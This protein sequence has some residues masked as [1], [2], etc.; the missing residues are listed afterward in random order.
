MCE[1][2]GEETI[3][4]RRLLKSVN[5][6]LIS[7]HGSDTNV[8]F[9]CIYAFTPQISKYGGCVSTGSVFNLKYL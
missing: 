6:L 2:E 8:Y 7:T 1:D 9:N 3:C 5:T 4:D